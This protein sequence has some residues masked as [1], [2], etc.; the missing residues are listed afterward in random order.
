MDTVDTHT[1]LISF[2][3]EVPEPFSPVDGLDGCEGC[4][5]SEVVSSSPPLFVDPEDTSVIVRRL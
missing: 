3:A 4:E 5:G 1:P 2:L